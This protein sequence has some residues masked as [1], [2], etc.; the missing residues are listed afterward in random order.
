MVRRRKTLEEECK[1]YL[2]RLMAFIDEAG[3][4]YPRTIQFS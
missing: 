4:D 2:C 3:P 1:P